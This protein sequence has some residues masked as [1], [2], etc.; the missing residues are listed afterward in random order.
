MINIEKLTP[1]Q[2]IF[3]LS[4]L[5]NVQEND[6]SDT[7]YCVEPEQLELRY[8]V[9][10]EDMADFMSELMDSKIEFN[11]GKQF[12]F[13]Q[14]ISYENMMLKFSIT[15]QA[16]AYKDEIYEVL[17]ENNKEPDLLEI[18]Q[19]YYET[20]RDDYEDCWQT[21]NYDGQY[22]PLCPHNSKCGGYKDRS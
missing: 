18:A 11:D 17:A 15:D 4:A 5:E 10:Q 19:G 6:N 7:V 20:F 9:Y 3:I 13:F 21:T 8:G 22:C 1:Y 12:S 2:Q 16:L 14:Q